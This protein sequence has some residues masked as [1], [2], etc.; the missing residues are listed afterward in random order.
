MTPTPAVDEGIKKIFG[1]GITGAPFG[2]EVTSEFSR[3]FA[4]GINVVFVV[5]A[6]FVLIYLLWGAFDF[7]TAA[8]EP[9][10]SAK[11][12]QKMINAVIG[13]ILLVA[14]LVIWIVIT[15]NVLGIFEGEG[16][17]F[18]FKL[19]TVRGLSGSSS[20]SGACDPANCFTGTTCPSGR[21]LKPELSCASGSVCCH[22]TIYIP[23]IPGGP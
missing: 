10:K 8:G 14:A 6:I 4:F 7:I 5:A 11:A 1:G 12:R 18:E 15:R 17:G 2:G 9:D 20:T 23:A 3:L 21:T 16:G 19:P 22:S 13:S